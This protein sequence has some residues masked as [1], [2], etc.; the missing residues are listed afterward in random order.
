M[1]DVTKFYNFDNDELLTVE[2]PDG[3]MTEVKLDHEPCISE[4]QVILIFNTAY[5]VKKIDWSFSGTVNTK[6]YVQPQ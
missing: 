3:T 6:I 5:D 1:S 4:G 2:A